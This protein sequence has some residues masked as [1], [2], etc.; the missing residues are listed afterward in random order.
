MAGIPM[1]N[2]RTLPRGPLRDLTL[3]VHDLY[4]A[5]GRPP[6]RDIAQRIA[7]TPTLRGTASHESV[8]AVHERSADPLGGI[9][10]G[11]PST[12]SDGASAAR[13][14][15]RRGHA[16]PRSEP[17]YRVSCGSTVNRTAPEAPGVTRPKTEP[18]RIPGNWPKSSTR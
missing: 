7:E 15:D 6:V 9:G 14:E 11:R 8:R 12:S 1:P 4:R 3:A 17:C 5:A 2:E 18:G 13:S 16:G 10:V